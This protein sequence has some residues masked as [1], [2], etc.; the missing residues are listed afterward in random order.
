[1]RRWLR[2]DRDVHHVIDPGSG[3]PAG[4][5]WRTVTVAAA[6]CVDANI[7][8]TAAIVLGPDAPAWLEARHLPARLVAR[9]GSVLRVAGW[10]AEA[11]VAC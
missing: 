2:G 5:H 9:D 8:S 4:D 1:V 11:E 10:P 3:E 7:A 6:S